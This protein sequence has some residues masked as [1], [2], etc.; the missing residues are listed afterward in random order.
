[1][2]KYVDKK[3]SAAT[4]AIIRSVVVA[5]EVNLRNTLHAGNEAYKQWLRNLGQMSPEVQNKGISGST[6][7][8]DVI[9]K[10]DKEQQKFT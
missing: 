10:L 9:Q 8:T 6:K 2:C 1:M 7:K 4:L 3:G 5:P